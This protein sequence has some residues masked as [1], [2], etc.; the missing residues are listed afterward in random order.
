MPHPMTRS[1]H[2]EAVEAAA[3]RQQHRRK[4]DERFKELMVLRS[5]LE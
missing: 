2:D 3:R 1:T 5:L 4:K